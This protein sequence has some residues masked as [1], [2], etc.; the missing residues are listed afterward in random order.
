MP[1]TVHNW[2]D[3]RRSEKLASLN[4]IV[5]SDNNWTIYKNT[6]MVAELLLLSLIFKFIYIAVLISPCPETGD[7]CDRTCACPHTC[8]ILC[9]CVYQIGTV[10]CLPPFGFITLVYPVLP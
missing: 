10:L 7:K 8:E 2:K 6:M 1:W 9:N 3:H 5:A 4:F